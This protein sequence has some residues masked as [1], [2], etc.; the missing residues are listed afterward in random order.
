MIRLL[1]LVFAAALCLVPDASATPPRS[2]HSR[3][4]HARSERR[5]P[6]VRPHA[7]GQNQAQHDRPAGIPAREPVS[8]DGFPTG[9]CPGY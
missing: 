9:A 7:F 1:A 6:I 5:F 2:S 3:A 4:V 8:V